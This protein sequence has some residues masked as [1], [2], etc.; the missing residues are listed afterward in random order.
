M[1]KHIKRISVYAVI[2]IV[3]C[4]LVVW[5]VS[6][7]K[8]ECLTYKYRAEFEGAYESNPMITDVKY[9]KVLNC[10]GELAEVYYISEDCGDVLVFKNINGSWEEIG[11]RTV[12]SKR[13]SASDVMW[14]YLWWSSITG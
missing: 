12:W 13:G 9:F 10:D 3:A 11:W 5:L 2:A 8:C 4:I 14:P 7:I 1:N 6:L